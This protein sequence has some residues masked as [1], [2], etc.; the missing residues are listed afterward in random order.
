MACS[1]SASRS[2]L[3]ELRQAKV[4][5]SA[6]LQYAPEGRY[7]LAIMPSKTYDA[8]LAAGAPK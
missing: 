4:S 5:T 3:D 2:P 7:A 8:L 6:V 1:F